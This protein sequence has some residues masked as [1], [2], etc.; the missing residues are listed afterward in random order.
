MIKSFDV[1]NPK[2]EINGYYLLEASAGTGKTFTIAHL[3]LRLILEGDKP[4]SIKKIGTVTFTKAAAK[5]LFDRIYTLIDTTLDLVKSKKAC[6]S[7]E[8]TIP[9]K[10][11]CNVLKL[12]K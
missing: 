5:E 2:E 8:K 9:K 4:L 10:F 1:L 6:L 11:F 7:T 12:L 3:V